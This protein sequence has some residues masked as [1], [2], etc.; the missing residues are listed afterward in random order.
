MWGSVFFRAPK[1]QVP[2]SFIFSAWLVLL[3]A[4]FFTSTMFVDGITYAT[5]ARNLAE[6]TGTWFSLHYTDTLA[7]VFY[8]HPP[9]WMWIESFFFRIFGDQV[10]V[11]R[12][13]S[14]LFFALFL[15]LLW[16]VVKTPSFW[17]ALLPLT[18][19][20]CWWIPGQNLLEIPLAGGLLWLAYRAE[21]S[22][23][24]P[25]LVWYL[26]QGLIFTVVLMIKGPVAGGILPGVV[27]F[28]WAGK[29]S[30]RTIGWH[31]F[32]LL[33]VPALVFGLM[34]W[35]HAPA[36][37]YAQQYVIQQFLG[38]ALTE[39]TAPYRW[40]VLERLFLEW[41]PFWGLLGWAAWKSQ[42]EVWRTLPW[43]K[44]WPWWITG[45]ASILPF[46]L[47]EK[48]SHFYLFP[49]VCLLLPGC[50]RLLQHVKPVTLAAFRPWMVGV[51][52][53]STVVLGFIFSTPTTDKRKIHEAVA[54][55][56]ARHPKGT[57]AFTCHAQWT[58]WYLHAYLARHG[59]MSLYA[60]NQD[61]EPIL[62]R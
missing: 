32:F 5:L 36:K 60:R 10:W 1:D 53:V 6:G 25:R 54:H 37:L 35:F 40:Y 26:I 18:L 30:W 17:L 2:V 14:L 21:Q 13:V 59:K 28:H 52:L 23:D 62:T 7:P 51:W 47:I 43:A 44:I 38:S 24:H 50:I 57:A 22:E 27:A 3:V 39:K 19:G 55:F 16:K 15:F 45:L 58:N 56:A 12:F 29:K 8:G 41:L 9:L 48:Q 20:L 42:R 33:F 11:E 46:L 61:C 31:V 49:G 34:V 4:G